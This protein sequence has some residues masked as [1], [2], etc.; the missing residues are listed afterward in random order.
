MHGVISKE[1]ELLEIQTASA[2]H[3][4]ED[5]IESHVVDQIHSGSISLLDLQTVFEEIDSIKDKVMEFK[6]EVGLK[7]DHYTQPTCSTPEKNTMVGFDEQL[8]RLLDKL[9]GQRCDR[10]VIPIV[11]MGGIGKTTLAKNA[12]E[13][14]LIVHR[15]DIRTWVTISQEYNVRELFVQLLS[16]LISEMD[17]ETNEQL[18]GQKLHKILWGRRYLI[19]IDDIW[20]V[21]AWEEVSR[22]FPDNNNGSRIVVTTRISNVAIYFDSPCFE[23]SFLD[24]DKICPLELEDIGKEIVRKCKGLPLSIVVIGGLLGRSNRTR[25]YWESVGKKL[26]SMLNSGKDE[27]CLNILSLSYTH[28][29]AHLKPCFLYMGIFPEDHEIR[30]SRL[31]KLWVVEGFIKLNKFQDLEE[32]ARGYLN[33]LIDRNLV[34]EYKLGSN[35]RIRLCKIHDLLRDLCL[36]VAQKDKFIRVMKDT[37]PRDIERERRI[38]FNERIMEEEYHSRSLSSLQSARTL[39]IRKDMGP[40]PSNNRLLRVLNVYDNSLS[41]KIYLSKCIFDQVNLRY[42]GYNTQLNI[43]GEL[44]SSIS[45]LWNMQTLIIEGNIF[46]PS[47][48]WEM[49]QLRHMDIYRLYLPDPPSSGPILRNLQTLKTVMNFT[50]SEEVCKRI[51]N[52]KKLNIMFHIEG[53]TIHYCL[54]NLSLLCK[55]ESL[56][57]SYSISN[58][59]LQKLTF[60]SSIKKLSLIFCRVNWEDLT[61]IGSLQNLEVLKLKYDSVRGAVWNPIEGEFLRLKFLL[62]HYSD[63]VYWNADSSNFPVLEKLVLKGMEKLEEIPLDIGEIPTLGFVHVN[64]CSESAA[65]SALKI[66]EEQE[67]VGNEGLRI[68]VE[69]VRKEQVER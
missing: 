38:V 19:V 48:I 60:P 67:N 24:E 25:E 18:L 1:A 17:S 56:T 65:I 54:H 43:Y 6:E 3:A 5:V 55:L 40:L 22:F 13:H 12:Y 8:L 36:K 20:S 35:G 41:K 7:D 37:T 4:A 39:V 2:F 23:L 58:N 15:F 63:L 68:R 61:L 34:S 10:Q 29:P 64:C 66:V 27:D 59:L 44:P 47:E 14:S 49:R 32:V 50:W 45:L 53:P 57:C 62:I 33:D 51:P 46:A 9:T 21:E 42:L 16:T 28:L 52:V 30:V 31:I 69:F 26:I 11:G